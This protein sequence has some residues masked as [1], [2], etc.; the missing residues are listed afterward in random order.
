VS[1]DH[2]DIPI[3]LRRVAPDA[4]A[5]LAR[6]ILAAA[7]VAAG[8]TV[9]GYSLLEQLN[10]VA[11]AAAMIIGRGGRERDAYRAWFDRALSRELADRRLP[12]A[13]A[14]DAFVNGG[15]R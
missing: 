9:A 10:G 15:T 2:C 1:A 8:P 5:P 4:G 12:S 3:A 7:S 11:I 6:E 13:L 14:G